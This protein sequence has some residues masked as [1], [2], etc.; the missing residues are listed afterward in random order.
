MEIGYSCLFQDILGPSMGD[1]VEKPS[2]DRQ[3]RRPFNFITWNV[4]RPNVVWLS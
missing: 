3:V 2:K 1:Y 4:Y